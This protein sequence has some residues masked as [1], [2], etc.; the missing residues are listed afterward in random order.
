MRALKE[1]LPSISWM[2]CASRR[3]WEDDGE[4]VR[5]SSAMGTEVP[6]KR[7]KTAREPSDETTV[8]RSSR[9]FRTPVRGGRTSARSTKPPHS[10]SDS[11]ASFVGAKNVSVR[12]GVAMA[13]RSMGRSASAAAR[14]ENSGRVSTISRMVS[15]SVA[16]SSSSATEAAGAIDGDVAGDSARNASASKSSSS[17]CAS[18]RPQRPRRPRTT[19]VRRTTAGPP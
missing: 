10:R 3:R 15:H 8:T 16:S 18:L 19:V 4:E 6:A 2:P 13:S 1:T 7:L 11:M 9:V 5:E 17:T 12:F 14:E